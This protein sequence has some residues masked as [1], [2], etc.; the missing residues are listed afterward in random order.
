MELEII[1]VILGPFL[2]LVVQVVKSTVPA[3]KERGV[4]LVFLGSIL[5]STLVVDWTGTWQAIGLDFAEAILTIAGVASGVYSWR[6]KEEVAVE[7][8]DA[9]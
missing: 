8:P 3:L 4:L 7:L 6:K 5:L 2:M 1:N 9:K